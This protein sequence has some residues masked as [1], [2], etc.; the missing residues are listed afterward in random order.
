MEVGVVPIATDQA[1]FLMFV[2]PTRLRVCVC[3]CI[4]FLVLAQLRVCFFQVVVCYI[5]IYQPSERLGLS[6]ALA[7]TR[8]SAMRK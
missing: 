2:L 4:F 8:P 1:S 7:S 6:R 5:N 3:V